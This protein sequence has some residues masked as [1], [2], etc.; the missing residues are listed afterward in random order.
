[1]AG[2]R[3]RMTSSGRFIGLYIDFAGK[4]RSFVGTDKRAETLAMA[5]KFEDDH[6]QIRLGYRPAPTGG[7]KHKDRPIGEVV[8]EYLQWGKA[9]GGRGGRPWAPG[10]AGKKEVSLT[11]WA[12]QLHLSTLADLTGILPKAEAVLRTFASNHAGKSV[13]T[14]REALVSFCSWAEKRGYLDENP[15]K[16]L[17]PFD[18]S[19]LTTRRA[20]TTEEIGRILDVTTPYRRLLYEVALA[21]GL[22]KRELRNLDVADL[23]TRSNGLA[24]HA[25]WT[26][27]RQIEFQPI[28]ADLAQRLAVFAASGEAADRYRKAFA[29]TKRTPTDVAEK[30][31]LFVPSHL[32]RSFKKDCKKAGVA[33]EAPGGEA[34]FHSLRVTYITRVI[35]AGANV[36]EAQDLAR[37]STPV[38]TMNV[39]GRSRP[40]RR[41]ELAEAV[42]GMIPASPKT[43]ETTGHGLAKMAAGAESLD[44]S[45]L[46]DGA[47]SGSNP[48]APTK[49]ES[50]TPS[51]GCAFSSQNTSNIKPVSTS[52]ELTLINSCAT[53]S[54][55]ISPL[56]P[57]STGYT[58]ASIP[59]DLAAL[60]AAWAVLPAD[61]KARIIE[62]AEG[63]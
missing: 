28:S 51:R 40:G 42:G 31:L 49:P 25:E 9:Q 4:D 33:E 53:S 21:S 11:F 32:D 12:E 54:Q 19:P 23:D 52:P 58:L 14:R 37:H 62:I 18:G 59:P 30:P 6:R 35:E 43:G 47:G 38:L 2:V 13:N 57:E 26:K 10:H 29:P 45:S 27:N 60:L 15:V 46:C 36:K 17:D 22:R 63:R 55:E 61:A 56:S 1:M 7:M 20:L 44:L 3:S 16:R 24:L 41:S 50:A 39:Y 5:R 8:A 34:D 48:L